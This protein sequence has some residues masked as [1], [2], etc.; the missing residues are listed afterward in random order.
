MEEQWKHYLIFVRKLTFRTAVIHSENI[1]D[2]R[3]LCN[4]IHPTAYI[5][6]F[7]KRMKQTSLVQ[8]Y[9]LM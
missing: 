8:L 3:F 7:P 2:I 5:S 6:F 4:N 9:I 1:H